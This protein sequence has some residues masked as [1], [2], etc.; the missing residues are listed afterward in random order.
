MLSPNKDPRPQCRASVSR[1]DT[2]DTL[3]AAGHEPGFDYPQEQILVAVASTPPSEELRDVCFG[4]T[5]GQ[6]QLRAG[7][8]QVTAS[9]VENGSADRKPSGK[10][11]EQPKLLC[12][13]GASA[14]RVLMDPSRLDVLMDTANWLTG[15]SRG[16]PSSSPSHRRRMANS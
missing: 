2:G 7:V 16:D 11:T 6:T 3:K 13:E 5:P 12:F 10:S 4:H 8:E 14:G 1:M 9:T 15:P